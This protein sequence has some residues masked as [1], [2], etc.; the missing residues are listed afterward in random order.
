MPITIDSDTSA[1]VNTL[2][3]FLLVEA[4]QAALRSD[5]NRRW[6]N[7]RAKTCTQKGLTEPTLS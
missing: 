7:Y 6:Q 3:R 5:A 1:Q 4:A 2:L